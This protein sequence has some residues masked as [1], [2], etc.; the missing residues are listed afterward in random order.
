M[1]LP[2]KEAMASDV[3]WRYRSNFTGYGAR[4]GV[5]ANSAEG[6]ALA[7]AE[8]PLGW[9]EDEGT[10]TDVLYS[11]CMPRP[12]REDTHSQYH[13]LYAG[14]ELVAQDRAS[15]PVL[16]K[17]AEHARLMTGLYARERL[18]VHAG[19]VGWQGQAIVL[20]GRSHSGKTTLVKALV[21]SGAVYYSDE[22][23]V[24]DANGYVHPYPLRLSIRAP[25]G[26]AHK[27]DVATLGG[28]VGKAPL[29]VRLVVMTH[30]APGAAWTPRPVSAA[31]A[32][33]GLMDNAIAAQREPEV[34]MPILRSAALRAHTVESKRDDAKGI[35][36][37]L[38]DLMG[39][40]GQTYLR[41]S[42]V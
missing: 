21:D 26:T 24:L 30:Y 3:K 8:R 39:C 19:V 7:V 41:T 32:M 11:F 34:S 40:L 36:P 25:D 22:Y 9:E 5:Q 35:V 27:T 18:F 10:D 31:R 38:F 20:P 15:E 17:F 37:H 13:L 12:N 23:A 28:Q 29:P 14:Q 4:F 1:P 2:E 6:L 16:A 33:L 42:L